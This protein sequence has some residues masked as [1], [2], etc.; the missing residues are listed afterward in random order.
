[1]A[2]RREQHAQAAGSVRALIGVCLLPARPPPLK[3]EIRS[4]LLNKEGE[5]IFNHPLAAEELPPLHREGYYE[6]GGD[7]GLSLIG[8]CLLLAQHHKPLR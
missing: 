5:V 7:Q 4:L 3:F 1:M 8:V 6:R 2:P